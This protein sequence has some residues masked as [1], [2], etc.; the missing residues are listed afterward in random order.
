[1]FLF[2]F[3]FLLDRWLCSFL[4]IGKLRNKEKTRRANILKKGG[5]RKQ[6]LS[7]HFFS[8]SLLFPLSLP[9]L[10]S[11]TILNKNSPNK[12]PAKVIE[13]SLL[14]V[15]VCLGLNVQV[16]QFKKKLGNTSNS[17][18]HIVNFHASINMVTIHVIRL[19]GK[20][21]FD[22]YLMIWVEM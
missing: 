15:E 12:L 4:D 17:G 14:V 2:L 22:S 18:Q 1:M 19:V 9:L 16:G 20:R 7:M 3:H 13:I 6:I 5:S 10:I 21:L 11:I 8:L